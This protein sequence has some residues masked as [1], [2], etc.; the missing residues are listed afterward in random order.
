[1]K[2]L[3]IGLISVGCLVVIVAIAALG[4]RVF[5][6]QGVAESFEVNSPELETKVL[7]ATQGSSFKE[8]LVSGIIEGLGENPTYIKVIDVIALP[9]IEEEPWN[10]LIL[11][12]T[13]QSSSLQPDVKEYL[14]Q[15]KKPD[16]IVLLTTSGSGK[17]KPEQ[18]PVDSI[19]TASSKKNAGP[20]VAEILKRVETILGSG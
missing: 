19:S 5:F 7:I 14:T 17:W 18:S 11:I 20:L 16:H 2:A 6:T 8:T 12:T 3:K 9:E 1:M 13:C 4:Y 10:A 15:T